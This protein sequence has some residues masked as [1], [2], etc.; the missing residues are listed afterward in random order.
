[1][2]F[3][4][5]PFITCGSQDMYENY[6]YYTADACMNTFTKQQVERM[7][8]V[9]EN[10]PRR[11]SLLSSVGAIPPGEKYYDLSIQ[12]IQSPINI[13]CDHI[14]NPQVV[15]LNNG[16]ISA[17]TFKLQYEFTDLTSGE[18]TY[19]G[20]SIFPGEAVTVNLPTEEL[21]NGSYQFASA[22]EI[23][24]NQVDIDVA[25]NAKNSYFAVNDNTDFIPLREQFEASD[26]ASTSWTV[27]N[28]DA[29]I[30]WNIANADNGQQTNRAAYINLFQYDRQSQRDW[31]VSPVLDFSDAGAASVFFK[32][33][34]ALNPGYNDQLQVMVSSDCGNHFNQVA[35]F[36]AMDLETTSSSTNW[37]PSGR[38]DWKTLSVD[39]SQYAGMSDVRL[40]FVSINGFGNNM[41]IDDVE[42]YKTNKENVIDV[43]NNDFVLYPKS[44]PWIQR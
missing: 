30:T 38:N 21:Q 4:L 23:T 13:T 29:D 36:R 7:L 26:I 42:F 17:G 16:T 44:C 18:Y 43:A 32:V 37:S 40:A 9:L 41:Y 1:M 14:I 5:V 2:D 35:I 28:P 19:S 24:E 8:V 12:S 34:Y 11:L 15:V 6:M 33:S 20:D 3:V 25:N 31:L 39:L 10:A 27:L 22:L